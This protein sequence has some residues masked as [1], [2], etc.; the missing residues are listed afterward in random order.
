MGQRP[1]Y[2]PCDVRVEQVGGAGFPCHESPPTEALCVIFFDPAGK[3]STI[4]GQS[5]IKSSIKEMDFFSTARLDA[6]VRLQVVI[7]GSCTAPLR[8]NDEEIRQQPQRAGHPS[9][10]FLEQG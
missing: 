5:S 9:I 3:M 1:G 4:P 8:T 2:P 7:E 10:K 6:G